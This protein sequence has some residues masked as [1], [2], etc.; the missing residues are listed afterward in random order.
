MRVSETGLDLIKSFEGLR[1]I[2]YKP[3]KAE[4]YYTI[5]FGHYG[6]DVLPGMHITYEQALDLLRKDIQKYETHVSLSDS[7]YHWTQNE[8]DALVSFAF[9]VGSIT[10]L[11]AKNTRTKAQ[12][13][14]KMLLYVKGSGKPLPGLIRRRIKEHDLFLSAPDMRQIALE[15][16]DGKWG[17]GAERR[18]RLT[19][20]GYDYKSVQ[21]LVNKILKER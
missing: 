5:G 18:E 13:A 20:A 7:V 15:V 8:F 3:V 17:N 2:A 9:N 4:T 11:T 1:L 19:A 10:Q 12:I 14:A 6:P 21:V 16:I